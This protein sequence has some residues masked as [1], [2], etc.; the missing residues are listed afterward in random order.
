MSKEVGVKSLTIKIGAREIS[1]DVAEAKKLKEALEDL[2]GKEVI[3]EVRVEKWHDPIW[4]YTGPVWMSADTIGAEATWKAPWGEVLCT[5]SG[6]L[7]L[8]VK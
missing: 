1:L 4:R 5:N 7:A 2:F 3:R 6:H 8:E